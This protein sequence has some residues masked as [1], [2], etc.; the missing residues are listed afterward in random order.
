MKRRTLPACIALFVAC[1]GRSEPPHPAAMEPT[2][3]DAPSVGDGRRSSSSD[4]RAARFAKRL[5]GADAVHVTGGDLSRGAGGPP[6]GDPLFDVTRPDDVREFVALFRFESGPDPPMCDCWGGPWFEFRRGTSRLAELSLHHLHTIRGEGP[7]NDDAVGVDGVLTE[8]SVAALCSWLA[9]HGVPG[10]AKAREDAEKNRLTGERVAARQRDILGAALFD[11]VV[12][13]SDEA[14]AWGAIRA[15]IADDRA[16]A[17]AVLR[18]LGA[19][20]LG[21]NDT[22]TACVR[23]RGNDV[24]TVNA[25]AGVAER[26]F[27]DDETLRGFGIWLADAA[28]NLR[29]NAATES[30]VAPRIE[31]AGRRVLTDDEADVRTV[32]IQG[33]RRIPRPDSVALL[34]EVLSGRMARTTGGEPFAFDSA[35]VADVAE[36]LAL[37]LGD[38]ASLPRVRE[39]AADTSSPEHA[40]FAECERWL[41]TLAARK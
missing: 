13:A 4:E 2:S 14:A 23:N 31:E 18:V 10:P 35:T 22:V 40:R 34:R 26:P 19:Q 16:R 39:L 17:V 24:A 8:E 41:S 15:G 1:C 36:I 12:A 25:I 11:R 6:V 32:A 33:L 9:R 3:A 5:E 30:R 7:E 20:R 29:L 27:A 37:R 21:G 28:R 38:T